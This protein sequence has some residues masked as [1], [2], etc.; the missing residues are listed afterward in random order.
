MRKLLLLL[1]A[2]CATIISFGQSTANYTYSTNNNGTLAT[3]KNGNAIDVSA[4]ANLISNGF[5]STLTATTA[6]GFDFYF[7][8]RLYTHFVGGP[9]GLVGLG[10]STSTN[11]N[12]IS[13]TLANDLTNASFVYPPTA[14]ASGALLAGFWDDLKTSSLGATFRTT[15]VGTA[16]NRCRVIVINTNINSSSSTSA[17]PADGVFH[18]RIYEGTG[19]VEYVYGKMSIGTG[20]TTVTSSIG[21]SAGSTDNTFIA[22]DNLPAYTVTRLAASEPATQSLVNSS[23]VGNIAELNS[24]ADGSRRFFRFTPPSSV[25]APTGLNFTS[26]SQTGMTVNWTDIAGE[27]FYMLQRSDDGGATY[28][29]V[30]TLAANTSTSI[31]SGLL[32]GVTY[33]WRVISVSEGVISTPLAGSQATSPAG[34]KTATGSGNWSSTT[35]NAPWSDGIVPVAT[36]DVTINDGVTVTIDFPVGATCNNLTVGQGVSG[37]LQYEVT[38]ARLLTVAQNVTIALGGT[39]QTAATGVATTHALFLGGNITNNGTLDFSTNGNTAGGNI[40]FTGTANNTFSGTGTITDLRNLTINKGSGTVTTTSPT[41]DMSLSNFTVRGVSVDPVGFLTLSNGIFKISG[42]NTVSSVVF[43]TTGYSIASTAGFWLNNAN[44]TVTGLNGSPTMSGLLRVTNGTLNIGT[45]VGNSM[46]FSTGSTIV[47]EG[48]TINAASR[49]GVASATNVISYN[50]SAGTINVNMVALGNTSTTLASFDLGTTG[51]SSIIVSGGTVN[52]VQAGTGASGPRDYRAN[53]SFVPNF[54][55]GTLNVGTAATATNFTFRI[56]GQVPANVVVTNN[57]NNKTLQ[58]AANTTIYGTLT[59]NTGASFDCNG[60]TNQTLKDVI[61]NG[62]IIGTVASSRFDFA[63]SS[64][65]VYSG[66]GTLGTVA[67]PFQGTGIG[68]LNYSNVTLNSPIITARVNLFGGTFINSNQIT[69]GNGVLTTCFVQRGGGSALSGSFDVAPIFN[70]VTNQIS[71]SYSTATGAVTTSFEIPASRT[72][73]AITINNTN[74]VTLSGG[75]LTLTGSTGLTLTT[76]LINTTSANRLI[77]ASTVTPIPAG[78]ATSYVSGPLEIQTAATAV[79]I[80][81]TFPIGIAGAFRP[82][83]I[84]TFTNNNTAQNYVAEAINGATGGT[85]T[86]S[87]LTSARYYRIQNTANIFSTTTARIVLSYGVDDNIGTIATAIVGQSAT[88]NGAYANQGQSANTAS[89]ITSNAATAAISGGGEYFVLANTASLPITWDGGA[90]TSNWG[91]ANNWNPDG[92]PTSSSNVNLN[93]GSATTININGSFA[94]NDLSI[95]TNTTLNLGVNTFTVN[96]AYTQTSSTFDLGSGVLNLVGNFTKSGGTLT[97]GTSTTNI[98]GVTQAINATG[99]PTTFNNISLSGGTKTFTTGATYAAAGNVTVAADAVLNLSAVTSTTINVAGNLSYSATV[100]GANIGSLTLNLTGASNTLTAGIGLVLP[101]I[102]IA[103]T[104]VYALA[105]NIEMI[106]GRTLTVT[107]TLNAGNNIVSGAG[108]FSAGALSRLGITS[109]IASANGG[110][111]TTTTKTFTDGV[112]IDYN[113]A[114][115][116]TIDAATH[117]IT[118]MIYT[119]G[120][121]TKTLNANVTIS[122]SSNSSTAR[123]SI[124]VNVGTTFA[125]GGFRINFQSTGYNNVVVEGTYLSTGSGAISFESGPTASKIR[126]VDGTTFGDL[127]INFG[128]STS[129]ISMEAQT[130]VTTATTNF[131]NITFGG[132]FG[133]GVA[134]GTLVA[135]SVGTTIINVTGNVNL[136]PSTVTN[137]G[138]GFGGTAATTATVNVKGNII[139]SST[140]TTQPLINNTGTNSLVLN[141]TSTQTI[142]LGVANAAI[143]TGA[144]LNINNPNGFTLGQALTIGGNLVM[145]QNTFTTG[146]N[147]LTLGAAA[148]ATFAPVSTLAITGGATNFAGRSV[149]FQSSV[150]GTARIAA[151]TGDNITTGL[152]NATNVSVQRYFTAKRAFRFI[153]HSFSTTVPISQLLVGSAATFTGIDITGGGDPAVITASVGGGA[154]NGYTIAK[155]GSGY[156]SA[157]TVTITGNGTGATATATVSAGAVTAINITAG[158]SG[159][160]TATISL[161][162]GF[163]LGTGLISTPTNNPS[164]YSYTVA[165]GNTTV[166]PVDPGWSAFTAGAS[167]IAAKQGIRVLVRGTKGEGLAGG[168]YAPSATTVTMSGTVND[169]TSPVTNLTSPGSSQFNLIANP[170][171][172]TIDL[173]AV[174]LGGNVG[175]NFYVWNLSVGVRGGYSFEPFAAAPTYRYLPIGAAFFATTSSTGTITFPEACKTS[176]TPFGSLFRGSS[177]YGANSVNLV[178]TDTGGIQQ[179]RILLF[180]NDNAASNVDDLDAAKL[181]NPDVNFYTYSSDA[182]K[183]C[184]DVRPYA[185][186]SVIPV[187][188]NTPFDRTF[189]ITAEDFQVDDSRDL[190]LHDKKTNTYTT[191]NKGVTYTFTS[192]LSDTTS[193][194][195]RF[196]IVMRVA[197]SLPLSFLNVAASQKNAGI[198]VTWNTANESNMDKYEV[199]ESAD[200]INFTKGTTVAANNQTSNTYTWYDANVINGD[201]YYRIK[202]IEKG[203]AV[204]YSSIV[205]VK[206][207]GKQAEFTVYPNPVKGGVINLQLSNVD[208]GSYTIKLYNN[209]GQE[210]VSK[211][212]QHN[213]GSSTQTISIGSSVPQGTYRMQ[214]VSS[215][216]TITKTIVVE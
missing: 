53:T 36:D 15:L 86:G 216:S 30:A 131:R 24:S 14:T 59:I 182:K 119:S 110:T 69:I 188:I 83:S 136:A 4:A 66:T 129:T 101:N 161:S 200:A 8:G 116:Q 166:S 118:G 92:V 96:G 3:D 160:T 152:L 46:G 179:D 146:A 192:T 35:L 167:T 91:D 123:G 145:S 54:S 82:L 153:G 67:T 23:V 87:N 75:T 28:N 105:T 197:G 77:L 29:T 81:R 93:L 196:E 18:I 114:G 180:L 26:L 194:G 58:A 149:T 177:K 39:F 170:L 208:K 19:E 95:G 162:G 41:L 186:N 176:N 2:V 47:I 99:S 156:T 70:L 173:Q 49:F 31:Q 68:I 213:G 142:T 174:T 203:G 20:S 50:Q 55:G 65:Q 89:T 109:A 73:T 52:L 164:A 133:T 143:V 159:Y 154:V 202:S 16:P 100:G 150:S 190:L 113:A 165:N 63:G 183:L 43:L 51:A 25:P 34:V 104:G 64:A 141:G 79:D 56:T 107:G 1:V 72:V 74:G 191:L 168:V 17:D 112:I 204:K 135:N 210:L 108:T 32:P 9:D 61:N 178:L 147:N 144:T 171:S 97:G 198:E 205:K 127:I 22:I 169:G 138:G 33:F 155:A 102:T 184:I 139:S 71:Y 103:S 42:A 106:A 11:S 121:G 85:G 117:P 40:T 209:L 38:T 94:V 151:I 7:M 13:G 130:A 201:N 193:Y 128:L 62:S 181:S 185:L 134:G 125:D 5:T 137:T 21:I 122:G 211:S 199:E 80:S 175:T 78:S 212:I 163:T 187:T 214:I 111:I 120:S 126:A 157:P 84:N 195:N 10:I 140:A 27:S 48:G 215:S 172:S 148:T 6:I 44:F 98:N 76:G 207:G 189:T 158:G 206:I 45:S 60:F 132:V 88:A 124:Y 12:V 115:N 37:I 57:T 90:A